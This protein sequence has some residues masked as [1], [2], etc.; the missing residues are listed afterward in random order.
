MCLGTARIGETLQK[1]EKL[2]VSE[3]MGQ[4]T[5]LFTSGLGFVAIPPSDP[6]QPPNCIYL[7]SFVALR[8]KSAFL[9]MSNE[10]TEFAIG[11]FHNPIAIILTMCSRT[12]GTFFSLPL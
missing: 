4:Y 7:V 10:C 11:S 2:H 8:L 5:D 1:L 3:R 6:R 12:T 9:K